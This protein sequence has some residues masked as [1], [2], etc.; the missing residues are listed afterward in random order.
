MSEPKTF[1][2]F[3]LLAAHQ[4]EVP[5][6]FRVRR[7]VSEAMHRLA[8]RLIRVDADDAALNDWAGRLEQLL[9]DVGEPPRRDTRAANRK[10]F[11]GQASAEDVFDMMDYDPVGGL[12][13]PIAPRLTWTREDAD[14]VEGEVWLGLPYQGPPGRVHGGV[15]SWLL[16][17]VLSRALHAS[18]KLGVTG[19]LNIRYLASTP[20]EETLAC[21]AH[22]A[23][24][25]GRKLFIEGGIWHGDTQTVAADGVWLIPKS[26]FGG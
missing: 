24:Q 7:R 12:S 8:E 13:N 9:A 26:L 25:E 6:T 14:G 23:R 5:E 15:L 19:S 17:S 22:V 21:R 18:M 10:L 2:P 3:Q 20:I 4:G 11:S 16:D 1:G